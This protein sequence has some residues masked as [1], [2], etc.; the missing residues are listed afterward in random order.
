MVVVPVAPLVVAVVVVRSLF[1]VVT[2]HERAVF[3]R[4]GRIRES[5]KG[6]GPKVRIPGVDLVA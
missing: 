5:A 1:T 6:P 3:F 2:E 4:L